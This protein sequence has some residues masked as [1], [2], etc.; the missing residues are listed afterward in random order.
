VA[1]LP[2][3]LT[4]PEIALAGRQL[5]PLNGDERAMTKRRVC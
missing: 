4:D 2:T 1:S 3:N 5:R